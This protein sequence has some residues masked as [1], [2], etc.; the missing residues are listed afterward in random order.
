MSVTQL[1]ER[2][3]T[4]LFI[5]EDDFGRFVS[6]L[7][8]IPRDRY[9]TTVRLRMA[10]ILKDTFGGESVEFSARVSESALSR[11]Q[12]VVRV[13][14][15]R[16]VRTLDR[17][18]QDALEHRLVEVSRTWTDRLG[19]ALRAARGEEE[20][21]R[22]M[23]RFGRAFPTAYEETFTVNQGAG[24]PQ[25]PRPARRGRRHQRGA[26]PPGRR[27]RR[28]PPVQAVP[29]RPAQPHRHPAD[30]HPH[31]RRG[32]RRA[33]LRGRPRPTAPTLHVY[34]FGLRVPDAAIW[35]ECP[36][37]RL[38][39]LFEGAVAAVWDGRAE[40]DGFNRLVLAA[41]LTW[42]Q[43]VVL[44]AVAKYLR[45]TRATYSQDYLEDAL[46]SHPA[47]A[48]DL[49]ELWETRFDPQRYGGFG[50]PTSAPRPRRRSPAGSSTRS[51]TC[52]RSTTT[53]SSGP[54]SAS[55]GR[56]CAR[57]STSRA[58]T[59]STS[60]TSRSSSTPRPCPTCRP[61]ARSSRSGST[62]RAVEGVHLRFGPV[63]RGGLRWSDRRE[64][65]RTEV[66]GLVKAQM[67]KNAV[68]VPTGSKGGFYPKQLPDPAVDRE[69]WLEEGK[70]AYRMF[71]SGLLDVT[72]NR[73][74]GAAVPPEHVVRH[75]GD[76]VYL[77][78]AADKGT[79]TFSDIA[80][81]VAQSY[82][83]WLDD[84]FASGGSAGYDHKAM[85]ITA[86]GAWESVKRHFREMG[87]DT[88]TQD[89]TVVGVGDMSG[90]VFGNGM[91][92]SEHIRLVAAFDHRHV[93]IDPTPDAAASFAERR[94]LFDLPRSSWDDYDKSLISAGGGVFPRTPEVDPGDA[95]DGRGARHQGRARR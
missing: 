75:D 2:R 18:E 55:S 57:T 79:A 66:L 86:R 46:V 61:R 63:A 78:V 43:V 25:P 10:D 84:A 6:C 33:A 23:D 22:L 60:R 47:I 7:V 72:D 40:S 80:N 73:V 31:G 8:Y 44:R 88:Q 30:L 19:D 20:G 77:V 90:D 12:F 52:P 91:L 49:V 5:R 15:G 85:G 13:P 27:A 14:K 89:F 35:E 94:R 39:D 50:Q 59:A 74:S 53:G 36:H 69:A 62:A 41:Q 65:F 21:D 38:R 34:D 45:Q 37:E 9:N 58:P 70:A 92:L 82:G 68:I 32:R 81:G 28:H 17:A 64:D 3:R 83:F 93:F 51:T 4:K 42:R 54:S 67:V 11:L 76:D 71:I 87:V 48:R 16:R 24:R 95:R 29:R 56:G 1:Q 26:L